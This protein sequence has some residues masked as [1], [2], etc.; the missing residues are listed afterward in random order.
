MT[1]QRF[2]AYTFLSR[3]L[4]SSSS[5]QHVINEGHAAKLSSPLVGGCAVHVVL[6]IQLRNW[7]T[8][9]GLLQDWEDLTVG[10]S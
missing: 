5:F 4:S 3:R 6:T 10:K 7:Y 8:I 9:F 2:S 1:F